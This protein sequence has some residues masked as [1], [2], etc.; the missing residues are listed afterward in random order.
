[1]LWHRI[2]TQPI[3]RATIT[4]SNVTPRKCHDMLFQNIKL[5]PDLLLYSVPRISAYK[6][7]TFNSVQ[8]SICVCSRRFTDD[9]SLS[10]L[11]AA[12]RKLEVRN[13]NNFSHIFFRKAHGDPVVY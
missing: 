5:M 3:W 4:C 7:Y 13:L 2:V 11:T 1:M 12:D 8:A 9:S 6:N 10:R